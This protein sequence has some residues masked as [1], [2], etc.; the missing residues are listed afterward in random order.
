MYYTI[1]TLY[2]KTY[3]LIITPHLTI[4]ANRTYELVTIPWAL[5]QECYAEPR[6]L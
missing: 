2:I 1:F 3:E 5:V 4:S 6:S